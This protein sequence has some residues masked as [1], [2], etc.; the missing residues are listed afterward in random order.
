MM[1]NLSLRDRDRL[2]KL[3]YFTSMSDDKRVARALNELME[4][5]D[6]V[7]AEDLEPAMTAIMHEH[8]D[9]PT[10]ELHLAGM[11]FA[12][13]RAITDHGGRLRPQLVWLTKSIAVQEEVAC[14]LKCRLQ[15]NG[16]G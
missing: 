3:V 5:E 4:S 6:V 1:A 12:M 7:P 16:I 10:C 2:A 13:V 14:A 8:A 11:L 9:L 15:L